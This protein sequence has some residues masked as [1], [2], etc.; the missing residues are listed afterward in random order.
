VGML[1]MIQTRSAVCW[2]VLTVVAVPAEA[3]TFKSL[4]SFTGQNDGGLPS[5]P[6][7]RD[8]AGALYGAAFTSASGTGNGTL[9]KF[10]A[11][12]E[13]SLLYT[14]PGEGGNW[15]G[16]ANPLGGFFLDPSGNIF[17]VTEFG[18]VQNGY[19]AVFRLSANHKEH[20]IH[21][22]A[23]PP[24]DGAI[25]LSPMI[26]DHSG[27]FY[28]TTAFGGSGR[29]RGGMPLCGTVFAIDSA[30]HY[31]IIHN[32]QGGQDDGIEPWGNLVQ[33]SQG[34]IYGTT[35]GGG[36]QSSPPCGPPDAFGCGTIF[37]LSPNADGSWTESILY[38]FTGLADGLD[39]DYLVIDT[40]GNL[41]G[42]AL[43][44]GSENCPGGCGT[45]FK[46]DMAGKFTVLHRFEREST[47]MRPYTVTL[48]GAGNLYGSSNGGHTNCGLGCGIVFKIDPNGKYSV[49]YAFNGKDGAG[50]GALLFDNKTGTIYSVTK[51]GGSSNWGT[52]FQLTP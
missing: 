7:L 25:P 37:K 51:V 17:G 52:V 38:R 49:V 46:V 42:A 24:N 44:G 12:G 45:I 32:F 28:G 48:D 6:L 33:D 11:S 3:Q 1:R 29:C 39:P 36:P 16:G 35:M 27:T 10:S 15:T 19:G 14:F 50:P 43:F 4:Y 41:Y 8:G 5:S 22:F 34:N 21:I 47:G 40:Q 30:G 2:L 13:F 18:G 20:A 26:S 31:N 23:G 9:F